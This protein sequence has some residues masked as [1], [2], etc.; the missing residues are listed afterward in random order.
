MY[1]NEKISSNYDA[2]WEKSQP[3]FLNLFFKIKSHP[4]RVDFFW[5][6]SMIVIDSVR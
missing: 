4:Y 2:E 5:A 3:N 6:W 1:F